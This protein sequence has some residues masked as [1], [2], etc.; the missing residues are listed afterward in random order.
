MAEFESV[1]V[2]ETWALAD[3]NRVKGART[4]MVNVTVPL[5]ASAELRVQVTGRLAMLQT[6]PGPDAEITV[7]PEETSK[8]KATALAELG[9]LFFA[10]AVKV[11]VLPTCTGSGVCEIVTAISAEPDPATTSKVNGWVWVMPLRPVL[12]A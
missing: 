6:A 7:A 9:P 10:T 4:L 12:S 11:A 5:A 1:A 3:I 2:D 8:L